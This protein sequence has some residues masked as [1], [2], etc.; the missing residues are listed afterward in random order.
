MKKKRTRLDLSN[1]E[2]V[3]DELVD[4]IG[5]NWAILYDRDRY[6]YKREAHILQYQGL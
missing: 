3:V 5:Y 4:Q 2:T 6:N 1:T